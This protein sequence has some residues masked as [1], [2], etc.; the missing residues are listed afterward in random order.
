M[1]KHQASVD[2]NSKNIIFQNLSYLVNSNSGD[3]LWFTHKKSYW[4]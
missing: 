4:L 1:K 3:L 2:E